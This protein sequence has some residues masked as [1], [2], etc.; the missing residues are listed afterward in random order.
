LP[1]EAIMT[2][3]QVAERKHSL[4]ASDRIEGTA[5]RRANGQKI[6]RIERLM[7]DKISGKVAYAVLSFGGFLG[8]GNQHLPVPWARLTYNLI[9]SSSM[10][11]RSTCPTMSSRKLL[12]MRRM[13]ISI[14]AT[15]H[16]K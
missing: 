4:I 6:G 1:L 2:T 10:L 11:T 7:L 14:G 3:E 8:I 13:R 9:T 12:H 5:V 16:E 15:D